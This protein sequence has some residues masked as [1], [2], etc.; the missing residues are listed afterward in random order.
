MRKPWIGLYIVL[1]A[2][3]RTETTPAVK[4]DGVERTPSTSTAA[5][6]AIA[7]TSRLAT[8]AMQADLLKAASPKPASPE[9]GAIA[10]ML[11]YPSETLPAM[12]VCAFELADGAARCITSTPGQRAYR[13][14][15]TPRGDYQVLA[16][17]RDG[18]GAPGG[19]TGCVDDLS[20]NCTEHDLRVVVVEAGKT[21]NDIDPIDFYAGDAGV[22]WPVEP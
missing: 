11:G 4:A 10:G 6:P 15:G 1:A 20:V 2:C 8:D 17:P 18:S 14:D 16:Y 19:Y 12:R 13:I 7:N 3:S 5:T 22:D 9:T 21:T